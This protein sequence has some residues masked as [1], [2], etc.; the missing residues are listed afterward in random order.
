MKISKGEKAFYCVNGFL[1]ILFALL[2]LCPLVY[3]ASASLSS[4]EAVMKGEVFLLPK[5]FN[6]GA[7]KKVFEDSKIWIAY[8]NTVYY[9]IFG[10]LA[11]L[12]ITCCGAY[13]LSKP[14]FKGRKWLNIFVV[15][16]IWFSGGMI[17][18][19]L[20][21]VELG[22]VNTRAGLIWGFVC[23]GTSVVIMRTFFEG[24]P[25]EL[26]EAAVVDG[27]THVQIFSKIYLPLSVASFATLGLMFAVGRWNGYLWSMIL[28][29]EDSKMPLQVLLKKLVVDTTVGSASGD[30]M[31]DTIKDYSDDM[32][33]YATMIVSMIPMLVCYPFLQKYFKK[34]MVIGAV[35]G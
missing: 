26:E 30:K 10:T 17:P 12:F 35:K 6:L 27:A 16:T 14:Y 31:T 24:L 33:I 9:T 25:M 1:L 2:C 20:N 19:Y 5:G 3:V 18:T 7:Y 23:Q 28:F 22:L 4:A 13:P 32:L 11:Q 15:I 8:A 21:F 34:G 29:K